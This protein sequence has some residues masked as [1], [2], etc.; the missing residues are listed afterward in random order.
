MCVRPCVRGCVRAPA[1][2]LPFPSSLRIREM[3]PVV[4]S[5]FVMSHCVA[6]AAAAGGDVAPGVSDAPA[7]A[8][9]GRGSGGRSDGV[10]RWVRCWALRACLPAT[11]WL[12]AELGWRFQWRTLRVL[13][14]FHVLRCGP[15]P[16]S[17]DR[18][19]MVLIDGCSVPSGTALPLDLSVLSSMLRDC[20]GGS[21]KTTVLLHISPLEVR[22]F[23]WGFH[24]GLGP[25]STVAQNF[26]SP[27]PSPPPLRFW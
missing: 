3:T 13:S 27:L 10:S 8:D 14:F 16:P 9:P 19:W 4:R 25:L 5:L 22:H 15:M 6:A 20:F 12:T 2:P 24:P 17:R 21:T 23:P 1:P 18:C 7:S 11:P 26:S